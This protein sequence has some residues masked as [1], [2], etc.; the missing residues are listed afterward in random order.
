MPA[1]V[2]GWI[3]G[4]QRFNCWEDG[5]IANFIELARCVD[6]RSQ[7]SIRGL[8]RLPGTPA[9]IHHFGPNG[10]SALIGVE[11]GVQGQVL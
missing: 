5:E 11:S 3:A 10:T 1:L 8:D 6:H 7:R 2:L 9:A 4:R